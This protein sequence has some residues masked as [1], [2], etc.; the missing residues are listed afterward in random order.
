[1][2]RQLETSYELDD[3]SELEEPIRTLTFDDARDSLGHW[4]QGAPSGSDHWPCF[5]P[6]QSLPE[7]DRDCFEDEVDAHAST[8]DN[9]GVARGRSER[10]V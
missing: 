1:M 5:E 10:V 6:T 8:T 7:V 3:W 9:N 2:Q 4:Q